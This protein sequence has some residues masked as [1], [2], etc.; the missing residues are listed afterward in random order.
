[1]DPAYTYAN[2][3]FEIIDLLAHTATIHIADLE[4]VHYLHEHAAVPPVHLNTFS[5]LLLRIT[6]LEIT[7]RLPLL[8]YQ[9]LERPEDA[10]HPET[11]LSGDVETWSRLPTTLSQMHR[12][13]S[14]HLW[15]DHQGP[16]S[17]SVVNERALFTSL[18]QLAST[19]TLDI[20]ITLP[21]IHPKFERED[22]H[23]TSGSPVSFHL[24]RRLRQRWYGR[25]LVL[26]LKK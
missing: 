1:M 22:R 17:W 9:L 5:S 21:K 2:R 20:S 23:F 3:Y 19:Q 26:K 10:N 13:K 18:G 15:L 4:M 14:V 25:R 8:F 12:L 6:N 7:L 16:K 11:E 24:R